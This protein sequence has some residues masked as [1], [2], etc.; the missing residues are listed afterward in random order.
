MTTMPVVHLLRVRSGRGNAD[1]PNLFVLAH[2]PQRPP[3]YLLLESLNNDDGLYAP[4]G[5][6]CTAAYKTSRASLTGAL[7]A[8]TRAVRLVGAAAGGILA[9]VA[10]ITIASTI[11]LT[12]FARR[13]EIEVMRLVGATAW[14]IR[15]P[16]VVEGAITGAAGACVAVIAVLAAYALVRFSFLDR[17]VTLYVMLSM[18]T[19]PQIANTAPLFKL[20][21]DIGLFNTW[22]GL[23]IPY[24]TSALPP[25]AYILVSF[26]REIPKDLAEAALLLGYAT[27]RLRELDFGQGEGRTVAEMEQLFP[28]ALA[29]FQAD[30][31]AHH[32]PGGEDPREAVERVIACFK[33]ITLAY[34]HGRVL[35]VAHTTLLRL[36][37][38]RF[39][40][41]PLKLYRTVFPFI[42]NGALTEIRLDG[43]KVSLFEFN[44]PIE[45][46]IGS[47]SLRV[48]DAGTAR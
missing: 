11:R 42:R 37:L 26:S 33:D 29:A 38:C 10:L 28:E 23:I 35:V 34:P 16:F 4:I 6:A 40:G 31:V 46:R 21:S 36:A 25:T 48:T 15:W 2:V 20:W 5:A 45:S 12:V 47:V 18:T 44:T 24:L 22:I 9:L 19:F 14:F 1:A 7:L 3:L 8:V 41:I 32:L 39:L 30:P 27:A 13:G 43:D 17:S